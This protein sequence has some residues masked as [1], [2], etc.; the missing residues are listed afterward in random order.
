VLVDVHSVQALAAAPPLLVRAAIVVPAAIVN[1]T[2]FL[3]VFTME[4]AVVISEMVATGEG[5]AGPAALGVVAVEGLLL[6]VGAVNLLVMA[7]EICST[8][9]GLRVTATDVAGISRLAFP[10]GGCTMSVSVFVT[11]V[12]EEGPVVCVLPTSEP[13]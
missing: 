6:V 4:A 12:D 1:D 10:R 5:A 3:D 13:P 9:K 11:A 8:A 2:A 7:V